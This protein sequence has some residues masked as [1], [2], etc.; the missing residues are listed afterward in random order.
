MNVSYEKI[1]GLD[2]ERLHAAIEPVLTAHGVECVELVWRTDRG[3]WLLE[4]SIERA[5][6]RAPGIGVTIDL[7]A[8]ISRDLSA[9]LDVADCIPHRYTLEVGSPG[10]ERAL[11][12]RRDYERFAGQAARL[13]LGAPRAGQHVIFGTLHGLDD[14]GAVL[15]ETEQGELASIELETIQ[16]ARILFEWKKGTG[17]R[18]SA[19]AT[20]QRTSG[21]AKKSPP[22]Q[23]SR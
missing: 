12:V 1:P 5:G 23:R 13:K 6:A 11:Y 8:D 17:T 15:I 21:K 14:H 2:R 18:A 7:C 10:V 16:S 22:P 3:G 4:I 9:A 20:D 19:K